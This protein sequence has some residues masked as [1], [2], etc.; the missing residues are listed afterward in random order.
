MG[1]GTAAVVKGEFVDLAVTHLKKQ[2][3]ET[4][5]M[6]TIKKG[7]KSVQFTGTLNWS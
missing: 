2:G 7:N 6:G 3:I 4:Y 1:V 5:S